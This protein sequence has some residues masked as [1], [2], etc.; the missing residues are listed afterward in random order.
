MGSKHQ[1][2]GKSTGGKPPQAAPGQ[3]HRNPAPP[4]SSGGTGTSKLSALQQKFA[5]KLEGSR[6]RVI[7][8]RLYT[9]EGATAFQEF[10]EK[11]SLFEVYHEGFRAQAA[12]WPVNPLDAIIA[13]IRRKHPR[14]RVADMGCGDARLA[15]M[16]NAA[17]QKAA[18][19]AAT[20][21]GG[22]KDTDKGGNGKNKGKN[23]GPAAL[24]MNTVHSFD[25]VSVDPLVTACD[26]SHTPLEDGSVDI[27]VFCLSLMGTNIGDFLRE[28]HRILRPGGTIKIVEVRS[29]FEGEQDGVKRF[30]RVLK[31]AG[32]DLP[33]G[34]GDDGLDVLE[35]RISMQG[36]GGDEGGG[37]G[38]KKSRG[39]NVADRSDGN[40]KMF[41]EV[42]ARRADRSCAPDLQYSAKAC[43]YKR[44]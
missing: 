25:L 13:W 37:G 19:A 31:R 17:G 3:S 40:N 20:S 22:D 10:Q 33:G 42:E 16:L 28:A 36:R 35:E 32:F 6:F 15:K 41:F 30:L 9:T 39:K 11:P 34:P 12:T 7:N 21:G 1:S 44:R 23:K 29:R 24:N 43:I 26:V 4:T 5:K 14:A 2:P 8:E 18:A 27:V 38:G